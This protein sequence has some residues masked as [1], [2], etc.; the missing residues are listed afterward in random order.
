MVQRILMSMLP[1]RAD[2]AERLSIRIQCA[3]SLVEMNV[4]V[5]V[6]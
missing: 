3:V 2:E 1:V 4:N 6:T 5:K